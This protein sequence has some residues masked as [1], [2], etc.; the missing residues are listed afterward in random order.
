MKMAK[1]D[2]IDLTLRGGAVGM[3]RVI[4]EPI[5][6]EILHIENLVAAKTKYLIRPRKT[7]HRI[8]I[9]PDII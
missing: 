1:G 6:G 9:I 5:N 4:Q 7:F 3:L 2:V 8:Q